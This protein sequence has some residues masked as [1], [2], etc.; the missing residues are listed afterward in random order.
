MP[1][2]GPLVMMKVKFQLFAGKTEVV[3]P[4]NV[5]IYVRG[6][7]NAIFT[8]ITSVVL[9]ISIIL[10]SELDGALLKESREYACRDY[11]PKYFTNAFSP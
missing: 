5:K 8:F 11:G 3:R 9:V 10:V 6:S 4:I 2:Q 7:R 1:H